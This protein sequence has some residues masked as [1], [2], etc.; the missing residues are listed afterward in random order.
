[1][2]VIVREFESSGRQGAILAWW[3][4]I[5]S[6][7]D[8]CR[9][10]GLVSVLFLVMSFASVDVWKAVEGSVRRMLQRAQSAPP[11]RWSDLSS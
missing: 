8:Q 11:A 3:V 4:M 10:P 2:L 9:T 5:E 6:I 7:A 1:L